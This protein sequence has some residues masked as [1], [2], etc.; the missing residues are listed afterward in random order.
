MTVQET[1]VLYKD[2]CNEPQETTLLYKD[3]CVKG[4]LHMC[5]ESQET[6]LLHK[7]LDGCVN[8]VDTATTATPIHTI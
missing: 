5:N 3:G 2:V 6:I 8:I 1:T 4:E 7:A